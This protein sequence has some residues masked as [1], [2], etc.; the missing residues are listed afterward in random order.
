MNPFKPSDRH[1]WE[2]DKM[3]NY[4]HDTYIEDGTDPSALRKTGYRNI[5]K[6]IKLKF[7]DVV[8]NFKIPKIRQGPVTRTHIVKYAGASYDFNPIH[9]DQEFASRSIAKGIIAHGMM[10]MG[11]LGKC[12]TSYLG[13]AQFDKFSSRNVTMVRPGDVLIL[14]GQVSEIIPSLNGNG[15]Q[16]RLTLTA[17]DELTGELRCK[18][19]VLVT[20]AQG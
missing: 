17:T 19:E 18:G 5:E 2:D 1:L 7:S 11:Y 20:L 14:E 3:K 8:L 12:A 9:H 13:T 6:R 10:I 15:G 4:Y 16:V